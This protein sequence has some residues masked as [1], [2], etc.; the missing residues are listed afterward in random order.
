MNCIVC[1]S[2]LVVF[3]KLI[4]DIKYWKCNFCLA[5]FIDKYN[6]PSKIFEKKHYLKHENSMEDNGYLSFLLKLY[7][8]IIKKIFNND[9]GLDYGCGYMPTLA[10]IF[11][12]KGFD[13]DLYDPFFF[14]NNYIFKNKYNFITC[15]EAAEHFFT[16]YKEFDIFDRLLVKNGWLGLMTSF[17]VEEK[18]FDDWY[19][20]RDPT[21]VVFYDIKTFEVIAS[22]RNWLHE[23]KQNNVVLFKKK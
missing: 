2:N 1:K 13:V 11:K 22:Q 4:D 16:P 14:P 3:F 20:R 9:K 5:K 6:Y 8:P 21:H 12:K 17:L 15:S 19:Y 7:N 18:L 23:I 10:S